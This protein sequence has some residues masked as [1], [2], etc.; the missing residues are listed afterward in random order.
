MA[1]NQPSF[2]LW[3]DNSALSAFRSCERKAFWEHIRSIQPMPASIHLHAGGAFARGLE[4][5]RRRFYIQHES[6]DASIHAGLIALI[7]AYG[8]FPCPEKESKTWDR[9]AGALIYY[10]DQWP[11]DTDA[12]QPIILGKAAAIEFSFAIPLNIAHPETGEP[13]LYTGRADMIGSFRDSVFCVDEK[14]TK[15]LGANWAE[16]WQLRSQF[17]GYTWAAREYGHRVAGTIVRGVSILKTL[18]NHAEAIVYHND[19]LISEWHK[20]T[21]TTIRRMIECWQ[22]GEWQF[23]FAE[24]CSAYSGCPFVRLCSSPEPERWMQYYTDRNWDPLNRPDAS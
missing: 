14:T 15:H 1:L 11:M 10:F 6:L 16:Q 4:V 8:D 2:P 24:A 9:M 18:Y 13:I 19:Y 21:L 22:N 17:I 20:L 7:T 3:V 23:N 5:A 12:I